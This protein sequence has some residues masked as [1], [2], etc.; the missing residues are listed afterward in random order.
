MKKGI[1]NLILCAAIAGS[2]SA[3]IPV[4]F[5]AGGAGTALAGDK[6]GMKTMMQDRDMANVALKRISADPEL[7]KQTHIAIAGYNHVLLMAGQAPT[8]ELRSRAYNL[9]STV[10]NVKRIYNEVTIEPGLSATT[11][12]NDTWITTKVKS[13]ILAEK[14]VSSDSIK[15]VTENGVVYLMGLVTPG[16]ANAV[17]NAS[18]RISGV[19]KV[20]KIFEYEQ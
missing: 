11:I 13:A 9:I 5:V 17:A 20:V 16:Q 2:L 15:V 12:A 4:A 10:P 19:K 1:V 8:E 7:K 6:R 18:S 14:G 3:C